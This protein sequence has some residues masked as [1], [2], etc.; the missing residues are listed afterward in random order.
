MDITPTWT[1]APPSL[2]K[3]Y[4]DRDRIYGT[5][6]PNA[7]SLEPKDHTTKGNLKMTT[8]ALTTRTNNTAVVSM[9]GDY[10]PFAALAAS[11][12][13][14]GMQGEPLKFSKGRWFAGRS[15]AEQD[16]G[17]KLLIAD[18]EN[19]M[20][21]WR[22]WRDKRITDQM[23]G[24]VADNFK[25]PQRNDLGDLDERD[26]ERDSA[27]KPSDPWQ[28]GF[29]LRLVDPDS[30][31]A[32]AWSATSNGAR[33]AMGDLVNAFA[34]RRRKNPESC[35]PVVRLDS[36]FYRHKDFGRVDVPKFEIVEWRASDTA[37]SLPA[38]DGSDHARMD[39]DIP[40]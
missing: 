19:L 31:E 29:F 18:L 2:L 21:G 30:E 17:G 34:R 11:L 35:I 38:P 20:T 40:F 36:D 10:D 27:G 25:P 7:T 5:S 8:T 24:L 39:D 16:V 14:P 32:F 3:F 13:A 12:S 26:W 1:G 23:V 37:P 15:D 6:Q 28:F 4:A 9:D 33:R 22:R